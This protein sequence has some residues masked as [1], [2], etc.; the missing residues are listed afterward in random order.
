MTGRLAEVERPGPLRWSWYAMGGALPARHREWVLHDLTTRTWW[1]RQLGR[2][3][4]QVLPVAVLV[5]ILVPGELWVRVL[6]VLGGTA[7]GMI[8]AVAYLYEA[9]EH[10][11]MKAGYPRGML[12][13]VRDDARADERLAATLRYVDRRRGGAAG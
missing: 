5:L 2:S 4:V 10:R 6:A 1:L 13:A 9:T 11:A 8:Y 12:Q 3:L 7:V